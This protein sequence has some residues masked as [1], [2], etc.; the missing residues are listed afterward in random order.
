MVIP[1]WVDAAGDNA[2]DSSSDDE[3][4][5]QMEVERQVLDSLQGDIIEPDQPV[6]EPTE[7]VAA[8]STPKSGKISIKIG[9]GSGASAVCHV[10]GKSGHTSGFV[11]GTGTYVDC[12]NKP[13]YLCGGS[14]HRT[15]ACPHRLA[16]ELNCNAA[17]DVTTGSILQHLSTRERQGRAKISLPPNPG[18]YVV[19]AAVLK[20][21][22]RRTTCLEFHPTKDNIVL[23][24]DKHGQIAVWDVDKVFE[25]TVYTNLNKWLT[26]ALKF[27]P[28]N[29]SGGGNTD[30]HVAT[31]SYDGTVK[32]VDIEVGTQ[33]R[34][35][36]DANPRGW[37]HVV[38][39]DKA[40]NWVT[41]LDLDVMST[42]GAVV[43]GD[44]K[45]KVYFLD[46]RMEEPAAVLQ[47]HKKNTKVQ[48]VSV[49]PASDCLVLTA[50]NDYQARLLDSRCLGGSG[51]ILG[52]GSSLNNVNSTSAEIASFAHTRVINAAYFSPITGRKILTTAQDNRLRVWDDFAS[53]LGGPPDREIVH[54]HT[55]NRHLTAFTAEWDPKDHS[56]RLAVIGRYISESYDGVALHPI[57]LIDIATGATVGE[58]V[59]PNL[60]TI[61]P[62]N[63]PHPRR[64]L[65]ITGSSRSLYAWKP[66]EEEEEGDGEREEVA[67]A[68]MAATAAQWAAGG[69]QGTHDGAGSSK[70]P[71]TPFLLRGSANYL[72]F[73][74]DEGAAGKKKR[75]SAAAKTAAAKTAAAKA[76]GEGSSKGAKTT[77]T[78]TKRA[79]TEEKQAKKGDD[80]GEEAEERGAAGGGSE[81]E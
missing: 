41:F 58:L 39:E 46:P 8:R 66:E 20:L 37:E 21:H 64:D 79:K 70:G 69:S 10:C 24:G 53:S 6:N 29:G 35:L 74:A 60:T 80:D 47:A 63:K 31:A 62:V 36:V 19:D 22:A 49:N 17:A 48:S 33:V 40:G 5:D 9:G 78:K 72:F 14:G 28:E 45:G 25:R 73:D 12:I 1:R 16:P 71:K 4:V 15:S 54:S 18:R 3:D 44:S 11:P 38:E 59:D 7:P 61:C 77:T 50:G 26:N 27:M 76:P 43:S 51:G 57:D 32:I 75:T 56:E 30:A 68:R 2:S 81:S 34:T 23:S 55:F 67:A 42:T 65:I 13:C 52:V